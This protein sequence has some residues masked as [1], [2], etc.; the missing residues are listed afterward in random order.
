MQNKDKVSYKCD[1]PEVEA[2]HALGFPAQAAF[3]KAEAESSSL[4]TAKF[5]RTTVLGFLEISRFLE[6]IYVRFIQYFSLSSFSSPPASLSFHP[7]SATHSHGHTL[8]PG[9]LM[10]LGRKKCYIIFPLTSD[11]KLEFNYDEGQ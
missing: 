5:S 7:T 1:S 4:L 6:I 11:W 10:S 2:A 3:T 9:P 8:K